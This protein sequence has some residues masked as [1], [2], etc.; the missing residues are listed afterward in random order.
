M[1]QSKTKVIEAVGVK[2]AFKTGGN[3]VIE[4]VHGVDFDILAGEYVMFFGPSGCG[5]STLLNLCAALEFP[6]EGKLLIRGENISKYNSNQLA[7]FR[8]S[9]IGIIFQQFNLLKSMTVQQ[10][11][12]LPLM[13]AG[14]PRAKAFRR[15]ENLL[16][17]VGLAKHVKKI[18]TELS[19]GQQQRVAIARA[20]S[21]NPWILICDEPT[22]NLDSKSSDDVMEILYSLNVKS[23]RTI[24]LVTHNAD[25]LK[26]ANRV[27]YVKDG[28]IDKVVVNHKR[29]VIK[30]IADFSLSGKELQQS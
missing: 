6:T 20:L 15:A 3:N 24:L 22:G 21:A 12:A 29:P 2:K 30:N 13:A 1:A 28:A 25:Y 4:V 17:V 5:K 26:F 27:F 7:A 11:V 10:N 19:G 14:Q 18:H 9:K 23:K 8:Q 16:R